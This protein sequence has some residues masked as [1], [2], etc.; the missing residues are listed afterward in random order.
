[1]ILLFKDYVIKKDT[2]RTILPIFVGIAT[3]VVGD[4]DKN[5]Y[6][7]YLIMSESKQKI[8]NDIYF[9][10]AGANQIRLKMPRKKIV[11][12]KCQML[13]GSLKRMLK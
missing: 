4:L 3:V 12:L 11:A 10:R 9:D 2:I 7:N 8:I 13:R 1:M 6:L 5:I